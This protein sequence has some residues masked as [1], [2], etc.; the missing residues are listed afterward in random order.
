MRKWNFLGR[1]SMA[2]PAWLPRGSGKSF[3][4]GAH[5][6][7]GISISSG[8]NLFAVALSDGSACVVDVREGNTLPT[9]RWQAHERYICEVS[10]GTNLGSPYFCSN[11]I[12]TASGDG[13]VKLWDIRKVSASGSGGGGS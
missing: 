11:V 9:L 1:K 7:N 13:T 3:V 6:L 4:Y 2:E 12:M 8:S 10:G 5:S